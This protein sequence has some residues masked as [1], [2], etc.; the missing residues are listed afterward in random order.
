VYHRCWPTLPIVP[1]EGNLRQ[2]RQQLARIKQTIASGTFSFA[3]EFPDFRHLKQVP[4][5]GSPRTCD[6]VFDAFLAHC[7]SRLEKDDLAS[8][9]VAT[10]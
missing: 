4:S 1:S 9:T 7:R 2:A 10:Y 6:E 3:E 8:V 5:E